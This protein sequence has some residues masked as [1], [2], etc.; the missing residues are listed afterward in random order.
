MTHENKRRKQKKAY[1][2]NNLQ[3]ITVKEKEKNEYFP[4]KV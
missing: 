2:F 3:K 4:L 1:F